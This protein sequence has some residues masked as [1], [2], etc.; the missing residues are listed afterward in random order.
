VTGEP[1]ARVAS[2]PAPGGGVVVRLEGEVDGSNAGEVERAVA[3]AA[4]GADPLVVDLSGLEYLDSQGLRWIATLSAEAR[5]AGAALVLVAPPGSFA[6]R[7]LE[8]A[9]M[10]E[11]LDV[12]TE[13]PESAGG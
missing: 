7:V 2:S 13:A 4:R 6:S 12:R 10:T 5:R 9:G 8:L 3:A 1:L 11:A